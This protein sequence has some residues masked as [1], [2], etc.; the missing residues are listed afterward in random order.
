MAF[1]VHLVSDKD[2]EVEAPFFAVNEY[3]VTFFSS[4][5]R[6]VPLAAYRTDQV[7][8]VTKKPEPGPTPLSPD[9]QPA[10]G[11]LPQPDPS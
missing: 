7:E 1:I 8:W 5:R 4:D 3:W 2:V 10:V 6:A 11:G 9:D